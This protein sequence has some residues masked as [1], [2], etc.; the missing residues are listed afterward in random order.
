MVLQVEELFKT[1][2][3]MR[4]SFGLPHELTCTLSADW[5]SSQKRAGASK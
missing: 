4:E 2:L 1:A 5:D 3:D